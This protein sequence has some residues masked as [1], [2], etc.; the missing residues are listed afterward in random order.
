MTVVEG[1]KVK[2]H[3]E[4]RLAD[5]EVF[6]KSQEDSPLEFVVGGGQ[7]IPGFDKGVVGMSLD[8]EKEITINPE[9]AYGEWKQEMVGDI[10]KSTFP[11]DFDPEVGKFIRLQDPTGRPITAKIVEK[12]DAG[13]KVDVNHPLAGKTLTFKIKVID[14]AQ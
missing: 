3:Y 8:E 5:G 10:P 6:D 11:E 1:N 4:G 12:N 13:I 14:I 7:M 9:E 2:V